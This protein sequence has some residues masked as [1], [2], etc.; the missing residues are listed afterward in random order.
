MNSGAQRLR[1]SVR[2]GWTG[3]PGILLGSPA[4][5]WRVSGSVLSAAEPGDALLGC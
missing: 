2:R 1:K 3:F 4:L 5:R